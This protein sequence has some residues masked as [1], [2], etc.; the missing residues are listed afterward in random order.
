[1]WQRIHKWE[2]KFYW[3]D[4]G[5]DGS[6]GDGVGDATSAESDVGMASLSGSPTDAQAGAAADAATAATAAAT[7]GATAGAGGP[8][9]VSLQEGTVSEGLPSEVKK[10]NP[11]EPKKKRRPTL[12]TQ[13]EGLL[14]GQGVR[15]SLIGGR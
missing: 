5:G 15:K 3:L 6:G 13:M 12:L 11:S 4:G 10:E 8:S 1:M 2:R 7:A 9:E 14:T